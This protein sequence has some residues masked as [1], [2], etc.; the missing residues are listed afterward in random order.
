MKTVTI[1]QRSGT[2]INIEVSADNIFIKDSLSGGI[3]LFQKDSISAL[4]SALIPENKDI[5]TAEYILDKY[6]KDYQDERSYATNDVLSALNDMKNQFISEPVLPPGKEEVISKIQLTKIAQF[7]REEI[8]H[9]FAEAERA[10]LR[11]FP[12]GENPDGEVIYSILESFKN[13]LMIK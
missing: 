3:I 7:D 4:I 5:K 9:D 13:K 8:E 12:D 11:I 1:K 6:D 2:E 10:L